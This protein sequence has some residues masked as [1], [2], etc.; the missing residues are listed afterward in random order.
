MKKHLLVYNSVRLAIQATL[1]TLLVLVTLRLS[2]QTI[3]TVAGSL[4]KGDGGPA[5]SAALNNPAGVAVDGS[6]NLFIADQTN[7]RI[8]KVATDGTITTV[9]GTGSYGYSGDNGPAIN[10]NLGNPSGVAVDGTGN[11]FI[12]DQSTHTVR[13]VATDGTITTV[14][15]T[16]TQGYSGDTGPAVNANLNSPYGIAVDGSGNLF[17]ADQANHR[18][19]KVATD[20][21]ITTVAGTGTQG[22]SG[23][24]GPA[25]SANLSTPASVIVDGAGNLFIA[26]LG[27]NRIR[28]VATDETITTVAGT[29]SFNFSGDNGPATSA[30]LAGPTGVVLN[31]GNL[32]ISDQSNNRIR[33]VATDGTITTV[34]GNGTQGFSGDNGPATSAN[35]SSPSGIAVDG[36]GILFFADQTNNR[37]RK[38]ATDGTLTTV[39]GNG[40]TDFSGDNGPAIDA[41]LNSPSGVAVDGTG[42]LFIADRTNNRIRKVATNGTIT[43]VA[44]TGTY[45]FS[46][47][48]VAA[49]SADLA[50]P[51][52]VAVDGSGNLFIADAGNHRIRKVATN[53]TITTV[54][55]NGTNSFGGDNGPATDA[56]LANPT[57]V[58]VDGS[59]NLFIADA[60]NHRIRKVAT[61]GTITTVAGN[62]TNG[63]SGD[64][65]SAT[66]A[67]LTNPTGVAVDGMGTLFIADQTNHRIRK[68]TTGGTI[69]TVA[70]TGTNGFDGDNGPAT[71]AQLNTPSEVAI[72]GN[73]NLF[74]DDTFNHRIRKVT[75]DG[76]ITTIAGTGS[77]GF[78]GDNSAATSAQL[79]AP[80]GVAVDGTGN[81]FIADQANNRIRKVSAP[82]SVSVSP[83]NPTAVCAGSN[84]SLTA[85]ALGFTPASYSWSSQPSGL[86][87]SG[88]TPTFTAPSVANPTTYTL[89]VTATDGT[90][91]A[92]AS[93]TL[94]VNA[95]PVASL[96]SSGPLNAS[97]TSATLTASG[98]SSYTFGG[99]GLVSQNSVSGTALVNASGIYSVTVTN[100]AGCTNIAS[101]SLTGTDLTPILILPQ[102]NFPTTGSV[103]NFLVN[104]FEVNGLPTS[105]NN[106]TI[107]VTA[108]PGYTVS[109]TN[110]L[111]SID[112]SGGSENP[113]PV[114]NPNW[115][116]TNTVSDRQL[117]LT[118]AN[119]G[120]ISAGGKAVL[121]FSMTRTTANSG[122]LCNIQVNV[123]DDASLTYDGNLLNNTYS[124]VINAL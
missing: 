55:G 17:I 52:G 105:M 35:L 45:G 43:T 69:T 71:S 89:T 21:T 100:S 47:D 18:I 79:N 34:A 39:A 27:N 84:F 102:A 123:N 122:S 5:T 120:F 64:N 40:T 38:V 53:G 59:G 7:H 108:P 29:G 2:A 107:T 124:R 86:T 26:D 98:G 113:V 72:D 10:A 48:N 93:V 115:S 117:T 13:K 67:A 57:G 44:G 83:A 8:R 50:N 41:A 87:A 1:S 99:P 36:T 9:A 19:R 112:V 96:T 68:V 51:T 73:G 14:A 101:V 81:L 42:N 116:V 121:G 58:A 106:V 92:T 49:I 74:I 82:A 20:G 104:I 111:T 91:T 94:L 118:M 30:E 12:A 119:G 77:Q 76:T 66:D 60:G 25:V 6:G 46:G 54:A 95:L 24:T 80:F 97:V 22:Y 33:K 23:D 28:K 32:F 85:T 3:T 16:G 37:I 109:F 4:L 65:G 110:G 62:G 90:E 31:G 61:N 56:A 103:G 114:D 15:G 63:F 70:G 75:P 88:A 78:S 11:L